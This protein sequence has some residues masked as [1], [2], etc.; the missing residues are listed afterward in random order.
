MWEEL[1][2]AG[3]M[4]FGP[5]MGKF[6]RCASNKELVTFCK[7]YRPGNAKTADQAGRA[8]AVAAVW[9]ELAARTARRMRDQAKAKPPVEYLPGTVPYGKNRGRD[10]RS[11]T[12]GELAGCHGVALRRGPQG[13]IDDLK[14]DIERRNDLKAKDIDARFRQVVLTTC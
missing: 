8:E 3:R 13:Y 6:I 1:L 7:D 9:A 10:I 2:K 12:D 4:P 14:A 11:L 5:H